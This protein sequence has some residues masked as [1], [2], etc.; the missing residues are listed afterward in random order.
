MV[1]RGGFQARNID[2]GARGDRY[3]SFVNYQF[4]LVLKL[5]KEVGQKMANIIDVSLRFGL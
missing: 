1:V 3:K 2:L 5:S 4:D